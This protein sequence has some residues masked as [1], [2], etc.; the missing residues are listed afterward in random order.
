MLKA[1]SLVGLARLFGD[2]L[3]RLCGRGL[4]HEDGRTD[5]V[6]GELLLLEQ[7]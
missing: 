1:L 4:L 6:V 2:S 5:D 7:R 3:V